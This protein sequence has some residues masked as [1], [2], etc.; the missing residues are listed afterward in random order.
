MV[1]WPGKAHRHAVRPSLIGT[2]RIGAK[3][4]AEMA[5]QDEPETGGHVGAGEDDGFELRVEALRHPTSLASSPGRRGRF[6]FAGTALGALALVAVVAGAFALVQGGASGGDLGG[7]G[8][9]PVGSRPA[10]ATRPTTSPTPVP[11]PT[12]TLG[13]GTPTALGPAPAACTPP[14]PAPRTLAYSS[15]T[16]IGGAPIWVAS[17]DGPK[18]SVHLGA[19]DLEHG[20]YGWL[21]PI[22]FAVEPGFTA[23][24]VVRGM[25][26]ADGAPLWLGVLGPGQKYSEATPTVAVVL[27]PRQPG[28]PRYDSDSRLG[29]E[30]WGM[31]SAALYLP[32]A[33]CYALEAQWPGGS[34]R[35]TFAVGR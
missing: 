1:E 12:P 29:D 11:Y 13:R 16:G 7:A 15:I 3:V 18:A 34:W 4:V 10:T 31:W 30:A 5:M 14:A 35:L 21:R 20:R 32:A 25:R 9:T 33:G 28:L 6:R 27:D 24:V 26:L 19:G 2:T 23:P 17:F 8:T 22:F